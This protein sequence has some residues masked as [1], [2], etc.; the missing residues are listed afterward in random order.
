M[1]IKQNLQSF[2]SEIQKNEINLQEMEE[3]IKKCDS[4]IMSSTTNQEVITL[5]KKLNDLKD[6]VSKTEEATFEL[7]EKVEFSKLEESKLLTFKKNFP[8]T[9][10]E[11]KSE[12]LTEN[13]SVVSSIESKKQRLQELSTAT[14]THLLKTYQGAKKRINDPIAFLEN[15]QCGRCKT[16][17]DN[18][19]IT[20]IESYREVISCTSCKR[21]IV[22]K[23]IMY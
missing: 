15:R 21:I 18:F 5:E 6:Q 8:T 17:L 11:I 9:Y 3:Q 4:D 13:K 12:I 19:S 14:N 10:E 2:E 1:L 16:A 20:A 7:M 23:D 22:S